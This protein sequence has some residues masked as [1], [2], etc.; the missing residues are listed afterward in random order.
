METVP[1]V[2]SSTSS[3][4]HLKSRLCHS[5]SSLVFSPLVSSSPTMTHHS[6]GGRKYSTFPASN[7]RLRLSPKPLFRRHHFSGSSSQVPH[8]DTLHRECDAVSRSFQDPLNWKGKWEWRTSSGFNSVQATPMDSTFLLKQ[9]NS[10]F[11]ARQCLPLCGAVGVSFR[12]PLCG[13]SVPPLMMVTPVCLE[14]G[15][16][17]SDLKEAHFGLKSAS[18]LSEFKSTSNSSK[19]KSVS[20][21]SN[22]FDIK[23]ASLTSTLDAKF[24]LKEEGSGL[25]GEDPYPSEVGEA[26]RHGRSLPGGN[27]S[28]GEEEVTLRCG[29]SVDASVQDSS[30]LI[31]SHSSNLSGRAA[32]DD[33]SAI[34]EDH[35]NDEERSEDD[36]VYERSC[37]GSDDEDCISL[38]D[39]EI[40]DDE[41][42]LQS[43]GDEGDSHEDDIVGCPCLPTVSVSMDDSCCDLELPCLSFKKRLS[44]ESGYCEG[45]VCGAEEKEAGPCWW[46]VPAAT[47]NEDI[48]WSDDNSEDSGE[49]RVLLGIGGKGVFSYF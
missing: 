28:C 22:S 42:V 9:L 14:V 16:A 10:L 17:K 25:V 43:G 38:N 24:P 44:E 11:S 4:F 20:L 32:N 18:D 34:A 5:Q 19:L 33:E 47:D 46:Q 48:D 21:P 45:V 39:S 3:D 6:R 30:D 15:G 12:L 8:L 26:G 41:V 27:L 23:S 40:S 49:G 2:P 31:A 37:E 1:P 7:G 35:S 36:F 29:C 13:K